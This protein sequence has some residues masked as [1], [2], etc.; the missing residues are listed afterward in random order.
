[1]TRQKIVTSQDDVHCLHRW[2]V[3]FLVQNTSAPHFNSCPR[4]DPI[5]PL[6]KALFGPLFLRS[7][8]PEIKVYGWGNVGV[9]AKYFQ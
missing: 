8:E 9:N 7:K 1:M 4:Y 6:T 5:Y 3:C 2:T